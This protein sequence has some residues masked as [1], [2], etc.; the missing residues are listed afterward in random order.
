MW[1]PEACLLQICATP[2]NRG[3]P[4]PFAGVGTPMVLPKFF[5]LHG[6]QLSPSPYPFL[7]HTTHSP[8]LDGFSAIKEGAGT[9]SLPPSEGEET[10]SFEVI[11]P[12]YVAR[13]VKPGYEPGSRALKTVLLAAWSA[14]VVSDTRL[15]SS[16]THLYTQV[17]S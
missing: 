16:F 8:T 3:V 1:I 11:H 6:T 17:R 13:A 14:C 7:P 15:A 10:E 5:S 9:T 4:R 2:K 12:C